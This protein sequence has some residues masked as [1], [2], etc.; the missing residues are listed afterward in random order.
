MADVGVQRFVTAS[1]GFMRRLR[2]VTDEQWAAPTPCTDWDVRALAN[3]VAQANLN[4]VRLLAGGTAAEFLRWRDADALGDDPLA[5]FE[6]TARDCA[7]AYAAPGALDRGVDHPSGELSGR[8]ALA[9]RTA[10]TFIHTWDLARGIGADDTLD[11]DL[12]TWMSANIDE[13]Y[14]GMAET[15]VAASTTHRFYAA[16]TGDLP[17]DASTQDRLLH[18]FGRRL[19]WPA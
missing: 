8:Q 7:D 13:I 5:A 10:D 4:Y 18:L 15:P 1:D 9:V 12:V 11:P 17:A 3:H 2:S 19:A 14:A 6:A 16:P